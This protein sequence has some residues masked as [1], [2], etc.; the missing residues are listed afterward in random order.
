MALISQPGSQLTAGRTEP[1]FSDEGM[2]RIKYG[3]KASPIIML[4]AMED[5]WALVCNG[6]G[7]GRE[8]SHGDL[9][10]LGLGS[11]FFHLA[12]ILLIKDVTEP[13]V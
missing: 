8:D 13:I 6:Q 2:P 9:R 4:T 7:H 5:R 3:R 1:M 10:E 11:L 12:M